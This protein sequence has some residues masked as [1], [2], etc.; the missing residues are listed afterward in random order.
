MLVAEP[1]GWSPKA[2]EQLVELL[3]EKHAPPALF[4]AKSCVLSSFAVG[5]ATSLV[6]DCGASGARGAPCLLCHALG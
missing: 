3:F 5:R 6:I 2:R 1:G 4:L